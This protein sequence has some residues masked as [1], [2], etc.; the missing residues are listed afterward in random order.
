[1]AMLYRLE[2]FDHLFALF[3]LDVALLP[4][5]P[6]ALAAAATPPFSDLVLRA[7][8]L[9]LNLEQLLYGLLDLRLVGPAGHLAADFLVFLFE[10]RALL[11]D[12]RLENDALGVAHVEILSIRALSAR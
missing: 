5:A 11:R 6:L 7:D 10:P 9:D 2:V 1:M 12:H 8:A 3:E 4:T